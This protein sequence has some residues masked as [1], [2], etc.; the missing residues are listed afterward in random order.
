[1]KRILPKEI[2]PLEDERNERVVNTRSFAGGRKRATRALHKTRVVENTFWFFTARG[3]PSLDLSPF[4][5]PIHTIANCAPQNYCLLCRLLLLWICLLQKREEKQK[6][7]HPPSPHGIQHLITQSLWFAVVLTSHHQPKENKDH[8]F[9][10]LSFLDYYRSWEA[11]DR[12]IITAKSRLG[13]TGFL[14]MGR[15]LAGNYYCCLLFNFRFWL[16]RFCEVF[17]VAHRSGNSS[18]VNEE[19]SFG[20]QLLRLASC[21]PG[22]CCLIGVCLFQS[23]GFSLIPLW[24]L[25]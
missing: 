17:G 20:W 5:P 10:L 16:L 8:P 15:S 23:C 18:F 19:H 21:W 6:S 14:R 7:T 25:Y 9:L 13:R 24:F 2:F 3:D 4:L 22:L 11:D 12:S 1:M